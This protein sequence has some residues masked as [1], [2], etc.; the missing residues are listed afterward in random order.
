MVTISM[1]GTADGVCVCDVNS[2][3]PTCISQFW[4]ESPSCHTS[5]P[6]PHH[7]QGR[8]QPSPPNIQA[9]SITTKKERDCYEYKLAIAIELYRRLGI[10]IN[11]NISLVKFS[12][13]FIFVAMTTRQYK[14]IQ[15]IRS[16]K[17]FLCLIFVVD[18]DWRKFFHNK[19]FPIYG[20]H[21]VNTHTHTYS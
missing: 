14:F 4:Q 3:Q 6:R 18:G 10:F 9:T 15:F 1:T 12:P 13:G 8:L 17:Y 2:T 20:I 5:W 16:K 7:W 21:K 19:N 11:K